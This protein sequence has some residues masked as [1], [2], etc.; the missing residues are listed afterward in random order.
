MPVGKKLTQL[1]LLQQQHDAEKQN[2]K[3]AGFYITAVAGK[4]ELRKL[5]LFYPLCPWIECHRDI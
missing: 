1:T 2:D 4:K 3:M 5:G